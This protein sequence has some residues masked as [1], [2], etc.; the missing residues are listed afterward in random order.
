MRIALIPLAALL[1]ILPACSSQRS[2][3]PTDPAL[4]IAD[5]ESTNTDRKRAIR[6]GW[7]EVE[8]GTLDRAMWRESVKKIAWRAS[9]PSEV[10]LVAIETLLEDDPEDTRT[11]LSLL[12]PRDPQWPVIEYVGALAAERGWTDMTSAFVRSWSRPVIEPPDDERPERAALLALHPGRSL[13][14][15][16]FDVFAEPTDGS[17]LAERAR[18]D[19]WALLCR[20]DPSMTIVR[21]RLAALEH[22]PAAQSDPLLR[23]LV[24]GAKQLAAVPVTGEQLEWLRELRKPE[25]AQFMDEAARSIAAL[26]PEKLD[27]FEMRHAA[28]VRWAADHRPGWLRASRDDLLGQCEQMLEDRK[29]YTRIADDIVGYSPPRESIDVYTDDLV[30][31]DALLIRVAIEA[32]DDPSIIAEMFAQ[33]DDDLRDTTTEWGGALDA[34]S[35]SFVA[36]SFPPRPAQR[37]GDNRF[38]ASPELLAA[39]APMLYVYH[40]HARQTGLREYAGPS[41]GDIEFAQRFGRSC[42]VLTFLTK[43]TMNA[44]YYQPDGAVIDLGVIRRP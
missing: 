35:S 3:K 30:W 21:A 22:D 1:V 20:L 9:L 10:R 29:R 14:D 11:M 31:G 25:H 38:V 41:R 4:I 24:E 6:A 37:M 18:T 28:A 33:A 5:D 27:G 26:P 23:D 36:Y 43:D 39:G 32:V 40:F 13:E 42:L 2:S 12:L 17:F 44:D 19:A 7:A 15:V 8:A 16:I 34:R